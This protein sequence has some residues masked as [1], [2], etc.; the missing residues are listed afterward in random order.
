MTLTDRDLKD[1]TGYVQKAAQIRWLIA[2]GWKFEVNSAGRARVAIAEFNR[3]MVGG[4]AVKQ[5][6]DFSQLN[7]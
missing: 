3:K 6:P 4:R 7:G 2:H 5:E 1:L